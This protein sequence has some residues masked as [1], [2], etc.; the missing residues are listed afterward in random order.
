M[1][2]SKSVKWC[3]PELE[4]RKMQWTL[5]SNTCNKR[6]WVQIKSDLRITCLCW[7]DCMWL[8]FRTFSTKV[9][10]PVSGNCEF[11]LIRFP[12]LSGRLIDGKILE[13]SRQEGASQLLLG[14][15]QIRTSSQS[16]ARCECIISGDQRHDQLDTLSDIRTSSIHISLLTPLPHSIG[17]LPSRAN[18]PNG[19]VLLFTPDNSLSQSVIPLFSLFPRLSI[20]QQT[21]AFCPFL[22]C[23]RTFH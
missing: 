9:V 19:D 6:I 22:H 2:T 21:S 23:I 4:R 10:Y 15:F 12:S 16:P 7:H 13:K 11:F 8:A 20:A 3:L 18:R 14:C 17:I 1:Y 5:P